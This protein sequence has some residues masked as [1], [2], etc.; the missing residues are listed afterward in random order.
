[1][2]RNENA[3]QAL[4]RGVDSGRRSRPGPPEQ[5]P[6]NEVVFGAIK[7]GRSAP[8]GQPL[9]FFYPDFYCRPR[10]FTESCCLVVALGGAEE[11]VGSTTDREL[12][13]AP[14]VVI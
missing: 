10:N 9:S 8:I 14:K 12:H 4:P 1:M 5:K 6:E 3:S 7:A 2:F 13:P 11:L